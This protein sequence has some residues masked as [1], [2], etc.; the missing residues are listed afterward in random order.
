MRILGLIGAGWVVTL[1][2][3]TGGATAPVAAGPC[4]DQCMT[5]CHVVQGYQYCR[6]RCFG[7][8]RR[9]AEFIGIIKPS[10]GQTA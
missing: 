7:S 1:L 9:R 8:C 4:F 6:N 2:L 3:A 10:G 5:H